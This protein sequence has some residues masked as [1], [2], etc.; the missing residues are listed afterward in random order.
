[1]DAER[2]NGICITTKLA[3]ILESMDKF[4]VGNRYAN[5]YEL[6]MLHC[7]G[8]RLQ[9]WSSDTEEAFRITDKFNSVAINIAPWIRKSLISF[10][11]TDAF[12]NVSGP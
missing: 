12:S 4:D 8:D 7:W 9:T 5:I 2:I 3:P 11:E 1:M 10:G 6:I